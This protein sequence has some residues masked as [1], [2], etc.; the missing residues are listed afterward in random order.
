M[1]QNTE[2]TQLSFVSHI[3][4]RGFQEIAEQYS[5]VTFGTEEIRKNTLYFKKNSNYAICSKD[6]YFIIWDR[7]ETDKLLK[8]GH[9]YSLIDNR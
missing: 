2:S 7:E 6:G 3:V 9:I 5:L 1:R 8:N 4:N